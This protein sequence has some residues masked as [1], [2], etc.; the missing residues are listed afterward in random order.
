[1]SANEHD[2]DQTSPAL[3]SNDMQDNDVGTIAA[4]V[5]EVRDTAGVASQSEIEDMLRQRIEKSS[6]TLTK[7]EIANLAVQISEGD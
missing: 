5:V 6:V 3:D 1:M 2:G 4:I 7:D